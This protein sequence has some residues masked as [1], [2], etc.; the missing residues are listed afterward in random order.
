MSSLKAVLTSS[1]VHWAMSGWIFFLSE[2]IILSE[3]RTAL[4]HYVGGDEI[5]HALYGTCSTM[6]VASI[7]YT[8]R[9]KIHR[10]PIN[11][12][13]PWP[14]VVVSWTCLTTGLA[15]AVQTLPRLQIP[16][17]LRS[18]SPST[19]QDIPSSTPSSGIPRTGEDSSKWTIQVRCPFDF[20]SDRHRSANATSDLVA[21]YGIDRISRHPGLWSLALICASTAVLQPTVALQT[22]WMGP[23]AVAWI[24]GTHTDSRYRRHI[25]GTLDPLYDS[26]TSNVPFLA[27]IT[28]RQGPDA[29]RKFVTEELKPVNTVLAVA[30]ATLWT[31]RRCR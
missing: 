20:T 3:N 22:F 23:T 10:V 21:V 8:Y 13:V 4:I 18:V 12:N 19:L 15:M 28:G 25:G 5:Y 29:M 17:T 6:A 31:L 11:S 7:L 2:N 9:Y 14:R 26:L 24:G 16:V 1:Q 30:A 27:M